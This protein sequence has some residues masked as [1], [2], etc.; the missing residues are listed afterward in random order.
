[1]REQACSE[2]GE[3]LAAPDTRR[4]GRLP[5][6]TAKT[7]MNTELEKRWKEG[8]KPFNGN[9]LV[10]EDFFVLPELLECLKTISIVLKRHYSDS[11]LFMFDDWHEHDGYVTTASEYS[12]AMIDNILRSGKSL[13]HSRAGDTCVR[14]AIYPDNMEFLLRYYVMDEDEDREYPGIWGD[15][16]IC[17]SSVLLTEITSELRS[18]IQPL[19][20]EGSAKA[21]FDGGYAG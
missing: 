4:S 5:R 20:Y 7:E 15:F 12:W 14:K 19:L 11:G 18:D 17:G 10:L 2:D 21:Y 8:K 6:N 3:G 13:Y 9:V 1:M 16:D